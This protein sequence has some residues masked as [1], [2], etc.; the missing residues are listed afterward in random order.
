[1]N[2]SPAFLSRGLP[3]DA[4]TISRIHVIDADFQAGVKCTFSGYYTD[5]KPQYKYPIEISCVIKG[6]M[7]L[8]NIAG[9]LWLSSYRNSNVHTLSCYAPRASKLV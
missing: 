1:M 8:H 7:I 5:T 9:L 2:G 4:T 3:N 6:E